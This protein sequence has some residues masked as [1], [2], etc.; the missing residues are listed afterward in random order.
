MMRFLMSVLSN[1]I[2]PLVTLSHYETPIHLTHAYGGWKNRALID[3]F[4][5]YASTVFKYIT[6]GKLSI[7]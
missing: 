5:N 3:H 6:K 1:G 2:E 4:E 7:G